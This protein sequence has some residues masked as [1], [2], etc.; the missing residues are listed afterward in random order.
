MGTLPLA[1]AEKYLATAEVAGEV[2]GTGQLTRV[3]AEELELL[4]NVLLLDL[5]VGGFVDGSGSHD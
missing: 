5:W 2:G 3:D 1:K 4:V